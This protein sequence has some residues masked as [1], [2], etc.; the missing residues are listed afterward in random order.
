MSEYYDLC[1][2]VNSR[3]PARQ[4]AQLIYGFFDDF[5]ITWHITEWTD[6]WIYLDV[7]YEPDDEK[8]IMEFLTKSMVCK[9][10]EQTMREEFD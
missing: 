5:F 1:I 6:D 2:M 10:D 4:F 8:E 7:T 9:L 3:M